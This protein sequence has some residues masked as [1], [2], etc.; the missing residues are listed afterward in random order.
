MQTRQL[1][2]YQ[3]RS[4]VKLVTLNC[5]CKTM[6]KCFVLPQERLATINWSCDR[7]QKLLLF[8]LAT[9]HR[10]SLSHQAYSNNVLKMDVY[11]ALHKQYPLKSYL[12]DFNMTVLPVICNSIP[13]RRKSHICFHVSIEFPHYFLSCFGLLA[14]K[15]QFTSIIYTTLCQQW[16][17]MMALFSHALN[18]VELAHI[19]GRICPL[20]HICKHKNVSV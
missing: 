1:G 15:C 14:V 4:F 12:F 13:I 5:P 20:H 7:K 16:L 8:K 2:S 9:I 10:Y 3:S 18:D 17:V 19:E 6:F 11:M